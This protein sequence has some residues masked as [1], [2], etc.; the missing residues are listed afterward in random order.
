MQHN[1]QRHPQSPYFKVCVQQ[2]CQN[3]GLIC[4]DCQSEHPYHKLLTLNDFLNAQSHALQ[5]VEDHAHLQQA[6]LAQ[7]TDLKN[8]VVAEI[9]SLQVRLQ[10]VF[11]DEQQIRKVLVQ[12][13]EKRQTLI[14]QLTSPQNLTSL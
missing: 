5:L 7:L 12:D 2:E 9:N 1:C 13:F 6:V 14:D 11:R 8:Q 4:H 3:R 10:E